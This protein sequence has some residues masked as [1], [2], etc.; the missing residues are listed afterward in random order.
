MWARIDPQPLSGCW[1]WTGP[2]AGD[3]Y[4]TYGRRDYAHRLAYELWVGPIP[5]G[6]T[7]DHLCRT[8]GCIRP[9]HLEPVTLGENIRRGS[10][11]TRTMCKWGHPFDAQNTHVTRLGRRHC[12]R[13]HAARELRAYHRRKA[14]ASLDKET[15]SGR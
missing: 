15:G 1:L 10:R 9:D 2:F 3:G 13:C 6:L 4:P 14:D 5:K 11:A 7:L 8:P 12:R